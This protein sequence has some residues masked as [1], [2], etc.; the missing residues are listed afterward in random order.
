MMVEW[1][2]GG[3]D[4][5]YHDD[6]GYYSLQFLHLGLLNNLQS[7]VVELL[8]LHETDHQPNLIFS[9]GY[10]KQFYQNHHHIRDYH[11]INTFAV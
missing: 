11:F 8:H 2:S 4:D 3:D 9:N 10:H 5:G 7:G 6:D 1:K